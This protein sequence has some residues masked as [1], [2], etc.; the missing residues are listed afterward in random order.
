MPAKVAAGVVS[1]PSFE[2]IEIERD[3]GLREASGRSVKNQKGCQVTRGDLPCA[4]LTWRS[5]ETNRAATRAA[6]L[7]RQAG[8][9]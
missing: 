1:S 3:L 9:D 5:P 2:A 6:R 7:S 8:E 4:D